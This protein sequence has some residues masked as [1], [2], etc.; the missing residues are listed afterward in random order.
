MFICKYC[1]CK[2]I[3]DKDEY[4][5]YYSQGEGMMLYTVSCP[6]CKKYVLLK[7]KPST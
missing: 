6:C 5:K 3:A 4:S 1:K 7:Q 2:F